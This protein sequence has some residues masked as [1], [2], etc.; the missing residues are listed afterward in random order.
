MDKRGEKRVQQAKGCHAHA[1]SV[2]K[3]RAC[4]ILHDDPTTATR[5]VQS[6]DQ[7]GEITSNQDHI[8]AFAG[9]IR[10]RSHGNSYV[11]LY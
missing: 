10:S 9:D 8:R 7:L 11:G 2:D 3:Q 1:Y 4:K 5:E 6:L